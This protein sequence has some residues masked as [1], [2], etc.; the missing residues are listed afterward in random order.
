[1]A[2]PI[3]TDST[4]AGEGVAVAFGGQ[5]WVIQP[6]N[7]KQLKRLLPRMNDIRMQTLSIEQIDLTMEVVLAALSRDHPD[8]TVGMLEEMLDLNTLP[9]VLSAVMQVSGLVLKGEAVAG[10]R[11]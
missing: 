11:I 8:L 10:Q 3:A 2:N 4:P 7:F 9:S 1:M 6:L 5:Q